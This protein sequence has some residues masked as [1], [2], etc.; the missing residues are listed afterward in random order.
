MVIWAAIAAIAAAIQTVI[1]AA[2]A[3]YAFTQVREAQRT[4][5]LD[6]IISLR[7]DIDSA[8]SRQNRYILFN[9]LP[10]DLTSSL[11]PEQEKVVDRVVIEYENIGGLVVNGFIDFNLMAGLY[12]SSTERCWKR[13]EPWIQK[14]RERRNYATYLP[15]FEKFAMKCIE[16]NK[17]K[18]GEELQTF[19]RGG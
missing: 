5:W 6:I 9:E 2:A 3:Y 1:L 18:H 11:T 13:T 12:A 8:E 19:K 7:Q 10:D 17:Q 14:Q 15:N 16:Y 4:R